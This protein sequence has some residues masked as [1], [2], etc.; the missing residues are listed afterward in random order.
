MTQ[1]EEQKIVETG[2][3]LGS[4]YGSLIIFFA[5]IFFLGSLAFSSLP[6]WAAERSFILIWS[7]GALIVVLGAEIGRV[8]F[9]S[10]VTIVGFLGFLALNLMMV[11]LGLAVYV[12]VV[13]PT[14][15]EATIQWVLMLVVATIAWYFILCLWMLRERR[16]R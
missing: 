16:R 7:V 2:K 6:I 1:T 5:V 8:L 11:V 4:M 9:K 14:A 10:G 3:V 12:D 13:V 15:S